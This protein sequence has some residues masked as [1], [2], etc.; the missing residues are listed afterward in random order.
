MKS[1]T[2]AKDV[3]NERVDARTK[4]KTQLEERMF[5]SLLTDIDKHA[6]S[7]IEY[8]AEAGAAP[9]LLKRCRMKSGLTRQQ[10]SEKLG[11]ASETWVRDRESVSKW[12]SWRMAGNN[13]FKKHVNELLDVFDVLLATE[14]RDE[15]AHEL[16]RF[17]FQCIDAEMVAEDSDPGIQAKRAVDIIRLMCGFLTLDELAHVLES[18]TFMT[19]GRFDDWPISDWAI[20]NEAMPEY[21]TRTVRNLRESLLCN[22][23]VRTLFNPESDYYDPWRPY[24]PVGSDETD[25]G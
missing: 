9:A 16:F 18:L 10:L 7:T 22:D 2:E 5:Q 20:A 6:P 25:E 15:V 14:K 19:N 11:Q 13:L 1:D 23:Q 3:L 8:L 17:Y 21:A 24:E 4:F 12:K